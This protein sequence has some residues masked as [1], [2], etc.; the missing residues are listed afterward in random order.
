MEKRK[1]SFLGKWSG[2]F[3]HKAEGPGKAHRKGLSLTELFQKFPDEPSAERWLEEVR[4]SKGMYC[5]QCGSMDKVIPRK[6]RKPEPYW[7]GDCRRH[8]SVRTRTVMEATNIPLQK[9]VIAIYLHLT[10]LEGVSSMKL[11]R[12]LGVTQKT[13]WFMLHRIR[14]AWSD[15]EGLRSSKAEVDEAYF[16][17]SNTNR[18]RGKKFDNWHDGKQF[19]VGMKDRRTGKVAAEVVTDRGNET[20]MGFVRKHLRW[21][22]VLYSDGAAAYT[23]GFNWPSRIG[24]VKH[25][26]DGGEWTKSNDSDIHTNGIENV[27]TR[28]KGTF[29]TYIH[30][31]K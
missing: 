30:W 11:H 10:T 23:Q 1:K 16:G 25:S 20:L 13:A 7:C 14:H 5:P 18:H 29:R 3:K 15:Q 22:G 28:F 26:E 12:D 21:G 6:N 24:Y 19:V 2:A 8:F 17:G 31:S 27:W 4:W 9:W